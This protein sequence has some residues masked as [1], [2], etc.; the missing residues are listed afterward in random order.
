V[1][2][3][4]RPLNQ[5][6]VGVG[7]SDIT[8]ARVT[9]EHLRQDVFG[10]GWS[11]KTKLQLG[12]T[13]R[14]ASVDLLSQP[15]PGP[16]R[17]LVSGALKRSEAS[18]LVVLSQSARI[19][20]TQDT[21]RV[22]R[23]YYLQFERDVTRSDSSGQV[24]D[25]TSAISA[26]Y[27]WVWR[28]LD[29][30]LLPTRGWGLLAELGG[31]RS[32]HTDVDSGF[33]GRSMARL[34][35]YQPLG[36]SFYG[37]ARLQLGQVVAPPNVN[38]PYTQLFRAGGD[39]SVRGYANQALGPSDASGVAIGGHVLATASVEVARPISIDLPALWWAAFVDAGNAAIRWSQLDPAVGYG[40]G[41]RWRSPVGPLRIDLA[42][43]TQVRRARLHFTVGLTF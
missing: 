38:V 18:G 28:Q 4:E 36:A 5:A 21:E 34:T 16:Y 8:G 15:E 26:N 11:A 33:F 35:A 19:G 3:R 6:T 14:A 7:A 31:G 29:H 24:T 30:P 2:L 13:E 32:F 1:R 41:L 42:Y 43:G 25:D 39:D 37:Q 27:H 22:E 20:R 40:V 9:L 23:L 17:N 10:L 12:Q